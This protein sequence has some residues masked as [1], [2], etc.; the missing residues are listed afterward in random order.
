MSVTN[1]CSIYKNDIFYVHAPDHDG[2]Y[3][4]DLDC[5]E[6]HINSVDA[7]I[8]K[9][10]DDNTMYMWHYRLGHVTVKHMKKL[11]KDGDEG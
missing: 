11:H 8:C 9:I 4:L 3:L 7:K 1:G 2:L 10:S 6:S 5:N